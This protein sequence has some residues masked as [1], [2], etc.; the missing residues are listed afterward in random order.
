[1][2]GY[3]QY[4]SMAFF[5]FG[6]E[7]DSTINAQLEID[8]F[9]FIDKQIYGLYN[10]FGN[11]VISG[12][13]VFDNG[14]T[15]E[16][17]ISIGIQ[18]GIAISNYTAVDISSPYFIAPLVPNTSMYVY[19]STVGS[20]AT[21][22]EANIFI[23]FTELPGGSIK[24]ADILTSDTGIVSIDNT[25][26]QYI[27][28][29]QTILDTV[30]NHKHRGSPTKI[31][32]QHE[33]KN[34]LP[35]AKIEDFDASKIK[36]GR[37][38]EERIPVLD[39][40]DLK[41]KGELTHPEIDSVIAKIS[42][43]NFGLFGNVASVN[44]LRQIIFLKYRYDN[45]DT[46]MVNEFVV[47]PGVTSAKYIDYDNSSAWIAEDTEWCIIGYPVF[48]RETYF[49]TNNFILPSA[50]IKIIL[51]SHKSE[52]D[53]SQIIF[54]INTTNSVDWD[55]YTV[56]T[57]GLVSDIPV[58]GN[59]LRVGIKFKWNGD[60]PAVFDGSTTDF[61]DFVD[62]Y[63]TNTLA[64][65]AFHFR[66]RFYESY[67]GM[68]PSDL[69]LT[70]ESKVDQEKWYVSD[71]GFLTTESIPCAGYEVLSTEEVVVS[72]YPDLLNL[73]FNKVYYL[74][75]DVWDGSS[76]VFSSSVH[77]FR[78]EFDSGAGPCDV[79]DYLPL[80]KNFGVMFELESGELITLNL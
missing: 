18:T 77:T 44:L 64:T 45:V 55:N 38:D 32:L 76:Y 41:N 69:M 2:P 51:T 17:G 42:D 40:D 65:Q 50:P 70:V 11:G 66:M 23:S 21:N 62:F 68:T 52:P 36:T 14:Y 31:D 39:H 15:V 35:G 7:L 49:F 60:L 63:F 26:R 10:V 61:V 22:R 5:D 13:E 71:T 46:F 57:E 79:Y 24:L 37:F 28:F 33:V 59:N 8:R 30:N 9:A 6:D 74:V 34:Q 75:V 43:N 29:E 1:M 27:G 3:T 16:N 73:I 58:V 47:V 72:Y 54:G 4:Y 56:I 25:V 20:T 67:D 80:V 48:S 53:N 78:R 12:L 19:I